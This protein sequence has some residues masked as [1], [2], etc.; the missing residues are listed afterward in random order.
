VFFKTN[1]LFAAIL[2]SSTAST[3]ASADHLGAAD[4]YRL[5]EIQLVDSRLHFFPEIADLLTRAAT[6]TEKAEREKPGVETCK[7]HLDFD[8]H[9]ITNISTARQCANFRDDVQNTFSGFQKVCL[10]ATEAERF[11]AEHHPGE[12]DFFEMMSLEGAIA[13]AGEA[14][15]HIDFPSALITD[16]FHKTTRQI[17][18][19]IR[20]AKLTSDIDSQLQNYN[21]LLK[22]LKT[23]QQC[24][25]GGPSDTL[26]GAVH[27]LIEELQSA[28]ADLQELD[29]L[30]R[31]QAELDR[32]M[33][34]NR[35]RFREILPYPSLTDSERQFLS[36]YFGAVFW[37][38]RGGGLIKLSGTQHARIEFNLFPMMIIGNLNGGSSGS[39]AGQSIFTHIFKGWSQFM[40]MGPIGDPKR[41]A[42]LIGMTNRGRYQVEGAATTLK[43][44]GY[45]DTDL[46]A[47]GSQMGACYLYSWDRLNGIRIGDPIPAPYWAF[48]DGPTSWGE[49]CAGASISLGLSKSLLNG[50]SKP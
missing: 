33:V 2:M 22:Q 5:T 6:R 32:Q 37:R 14:L 17:I 50:T 48:I 43:E 36:M 27:L 46:Q 26:E 4:E 44:N 24:L 40:G 42:N 41:I 49:L 15:S 9:L 38:M 35:G 20:F 30:G 1:W 31:G 28:K 12:V 39:S 34:L 19:K 21:H 10:Y 18:A 23:K 7:S 47:G 3:I 11:V 8:A 45:D 29:R 16:D 13:T 25:S